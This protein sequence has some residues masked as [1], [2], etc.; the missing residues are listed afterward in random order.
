M[1]N[2]IQKDIQ[3]VLKNRKFKAEKIAL[4]NLSLARENK[5]FSELERQFN[6]LKI[7]IAKDEIEGKNVDKLT[8]KYVKI[9]KNMQNLLKSMHISSIEPVYYCKLCN[10]TG[11]FE[12]H[13]CNCRKQ[14]LSEILLNKSGIL[15]NKLPN[16]ETTICD[17]KNELIYKKLNEWCEKFPNVKV[18]NIFITGQVGNGKTYLCTCIIDKLIKKGVYVYFNTAFA[19]NSDFLTFCKTS[20]EEILKQY[21]DPDVLIIDDFGSEP[22]IKNITE[23]YFYLILNERLM[24]NKSTI[25]NSNLMPDEILERYGER[26]FSRIMSQ[27]NSLVLEMLGED[28]RLK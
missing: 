14:I 20:N 18:N 27:R 7:Q 11:V 28:K 9:K 19:I 22:I 15:K 3:E 1:N 4:D 25:I 5:E 23:N 24:K 21:L 10:D 6:E 26:I 16:F 17:K 12:N 13:Y 8:E 2:S